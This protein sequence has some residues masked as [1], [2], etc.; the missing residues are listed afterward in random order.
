MRLFYG[1]SGGAISVFLTLIMVPTLFF[2]GIIV[3]A[4]RLYASKTVISGAG[5]LTM[6][7][8]LSSYDKTLKDQYGLMAMADKPENPS[9]LSA[10][11]TYFKES[12]NAA[13]LNLGDEADLH[14]MIQL[15]LV[16]NSFQTAGVDSSSLVNYPVLKQQLLEYMKFRA[17]VYIVDEVI[18]KFRNLPLK[19]MDEKQDY[20]KKK[21]DYGDKM[22]KLNSK[23]T[24]AKF[25]VDEHIRACEK[26]LED[27]DALDGAYEELQQGIK[28]H[29]A[30]RTLQCYLDNP[31]TMNPA[32][33]NS[34]QDLSEERA[35]NLID[36]YSSWDS[37]QTVFD[38]RIYDNIVAYASLY[39]LYETDPDKLPDF[40]V[41]KDQAAISIRNSI[42]GD[43]QTMEN[44]YERAKTKFRNT[45]NGYIE[46]A[47]KVSECVP[48]AKNALNEVWDVWNKEVLPAKNKYETSSADLKSTMESDE[49]NEL[50]SIEQ[51]EKSHE[52][53]IKRNEIDELI[54]VLDHNVE[55]AENTISQL[56]DV[57]T[58]PD[59]VFV[60]VA[61][62]VD[63]FFD[64][65][66]GD[67]KLQSVMADAENGANSSPS[68]VRFDYQNPRETSFY[69]NVLIRF[70]ET[71]DQSQQKQEDDAQ[72]EQADEEQ[73][74][75]FDLIS[76]IENAQ[77]EQTLDKSVLPSKL[78]SG[79][80][81]DN[82]AERIDTKNADDNTI[83]NAS[84]NNISKVSELLSGMD[85]LSGDILERVYLMEYMSEMFNCMTTSQGDTSLSND[86]LMKHSI[87]QGEMEYILYGNANTAANKAFAVST[88]YGI[89][90][91]IDGAYVFMDGGYN[92]TA[93][94]I[95]AA[96]SAGQPWLY[97]IIKYGYLFCQSMILAAKD[98]KELV[99]DK[100][101]VPVWPKNK[102]ITLNYKEY[103]KLFM[104][105]ALISEN[106]EESLVLRSADCI[107][108]N[109]KKNLSEKYTML[110]LQVKVYSNTTF[111]PHIPAFLGREDAET[112]GKKI[113]RYQSV[114]AY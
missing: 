77:K 78:Y 20:V 89:R 28:I 17:P 31:A 35:Q 10:L 107:Q 91:A 105:V 51:E 50:N 11:E 52:I 67:N 36:T 61:P 25:Y 109:T 99:T 98:V 83:A 66:F 110:T 97:P 46:D 21:T 19:N 48:N 3:D 95:A 80:E 14:S 22:S 40:N 47:K 7:A 8:A 58:I 114:M 90:L 70:E 15:S 45:V 79:K 84:L 32:V 65:S 56:N 1:K 34:D 60:S 30:A 94:A 72:K 33:V 71:I 74:S 49:V 85:K 87:Y 112:D 103:L 23:L 86:D 5:E 41:G 37:D 29:M 26:L 100:K 92:A 81:T 57:L 111:L 62:P 106:S 101:D 63:P 4:S 53:E 12:C 113:I 82:R 42:S 24:D 59:H 88:I 93:S 76:T 18:K 108:L 102:N 27:L 64:T 38:Y 55:A 44:V 73:G 96:L 75:Y 43:I 69:Q 16:E 9:T 104:L 39:M 6:N 2:C 13:N 68:S 54:S